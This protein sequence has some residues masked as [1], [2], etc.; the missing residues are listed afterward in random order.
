MSIIKKFIPPNAKKIPYLSVV[1]LAAG[2]STRMGFDK[3]TSDLCGKPVILRTLEAFQ[4][5]DCVNEIIVVTREE[6]I[7]AISDLIY[8]SDL[9]K[10]SC[11]VH[12]GATRAE[13]SYIGVFHCNKKAKLIGIHDG[14]RPLITD[15]LIQKVA[16]GAKKYRACC[17]GYMPTD[18]IKS[19]DDS[20]C[21][22]ETIP[23]NKTVCV[24]T[25]QIFDA[26]II[27]GALTKAVND[28][29]TITDDASAVEQ[30]GVPVYV[31]EGNLEN[32]KLTQPLD[33]YLAE[34]IINER[35]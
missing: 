23:R 25:P 2:S 8:E 32:I 24:Q 29:W 22:K 28:N 14:A 27:K 6:A 20:H 13:S 10:V 15:D 35:K 34:K 1:V 5:A 21:V 17:P 11:V 4:N 9:S 19:L 33:F 7:T 31:E 12:G 18:T 26:E 16:L 30:L 3:I